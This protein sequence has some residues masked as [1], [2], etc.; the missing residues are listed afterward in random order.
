MLS[1]IAVVIDNLEITKR[2]ESSIRQ[3]TSGEY[4]LIIID[5]ASKDQESINYLKE[6]ADIHYRF[7]SI[8]SLARAWNKGIELSKGNYV[9]VVN[10][11]V[12]VPPDW[13]ELLSETL[14]N[15]QKAGLVSPITFWIIRDLYF[16]Y[17]T[18]INFD[19]TFKNPF[20]L[21]KF[22]EVVWG[23]F[24]LFKR[25]A[26]EDAGRFNEIYR[27]YSA[28]DLEINF[29]LFS[30]D[31]EIF[32]DP[33]VFVYHEGHATIKNIDKQEASK[34]DNENFNL[35]KSRWPQYTKDWK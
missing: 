26:L 31:Y 19:K 16:Q 23:E 32:I 34:I 18:Y 21:E 9:A 6:M 3:Y 20:K 5:N 8:V 10:N 11:D 17:E 12:V 2:F 27:N 22:R 13:F 14:E 1:I 25:K 33:R 24:F 35:F 29:Q 15:N 30:K 7:D 28:E 4:E